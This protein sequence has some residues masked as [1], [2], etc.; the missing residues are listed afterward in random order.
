[1]N[2]KIFFDRI[3]SDLF[4]G[5]MSSDQVSGIQIILYAWSGKDDRW[6]A[7]ALATAYHETAFT[8]RPIKEIGGV[9]YFTRMYDIRGERP[10]LARSM[11]NTTPGDGAKYAGRG[12]VQ[13]TWKNNY[14]RLSS[15]LRLDLVGAPDLAMQPKVAA[16]IM[17]EGITKGLFTGK[18]LSDYFAGGRSDWVNARRI[19]N[20]TDKATEIAVIAKKF[21]AA[22]I[23]AN[24]E[25]I[26]PVAPITKPVSTKSRTAQGT[27]T[28]GAGGLVVAGGAVADAA[29]TLQRADSHISAG[30]WIGLVIG[31][32]IIAG[33]AYAFYARWQDGGGKFPWQ[34]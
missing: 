8:M 6:T 4:N 12:F 33:A 29:D 21:Y 7:Y 10:A 5:S 3:R 14:K 13:L 26:E 28:A 18:K 23:S 22:I 11:G 25:T 24:T 15:L 31:V 17:V 16:A 34:K 9:P 1:M 27:A 2:R 20:G 32:L 30:T 19:I